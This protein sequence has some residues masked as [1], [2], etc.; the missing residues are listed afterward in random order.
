VLWELT[1][2]ISKKNTYPGEKALGKIRLLREE[3]VLVQEKI[4]L[5]N[6]H[7]S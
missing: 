7:L 4:Y 5:K 1:K 6:G 2:D 3:T